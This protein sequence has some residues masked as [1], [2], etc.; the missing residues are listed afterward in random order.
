MSKEKEGSAPSK[1]KKKSLRKKLVITGAVGLVIVLL[2]ASSIYFFLQYQ[3]TQS[4]LK[5]PSSATQ[6]EVNSLVEKVSRHY[7]LPSNDQV[8]V[9]TVSD[10]GK[11]YGQTFFVKA[12]NGDKVLIYPKSGIAIL[13]RPATDKIINIGPVNTQ[14]D[15]SPAKATTPVKVALYNGTQTNGLTKKVE[16]TLPTLSSIKTTVVV[17]ANAANNYQ[18]S[19]VVDLTG[20]NKAAAIQLATFAKGEVMSLPA[21]EVKPDGVDILIILGQ[22]YVGEP[23]AT[24]T[25]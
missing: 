21:G 9:A 17:K 16:E 13:Y 15:T 24:P 3:K 2:I 18:D 1:E 25:P 8:T 22:S 12:K 4:L 5:N 20:K 6:R 11:L 23:T 14:G 10:V 7:D 19:V